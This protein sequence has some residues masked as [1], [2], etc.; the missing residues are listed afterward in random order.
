MSVYKKIFCSFF[1]I[2]TALLMFSCNIEKEITKNTG[3]A[4]HISTAV[5]SIVSVTFEHTA[6]LTTVPQT[7]EKNKVTTNP[8]TLPPPTTDAV[9]TNPVTLPPPTTDAGT[10]GEPEDSEFVRVRDYIEN[11]ITDLKYAT[12][13][14]FT[15]KRI[16]TFDEAYLRYGTVRKLMAVAEKLAEKGYAIKIWD[17]FRPAAAQFRLW[18]ICPD[19]TYVANPNKGFSSHSRGNTI[20]LTVYRISD[21]N[22]LIMPTGF[23]DFSKRA[24]RDYSDIEGEAAENA[25]MLENLMKQFGFKPYFGEWWHFSDVDSYPVEK[26]FLSDEITKG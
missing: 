20:D 21:Q 24:D 25:I 26:D 7:T 23:D 9:T 11:V 17:A 15:G 18:E 8:A 12:E 16:Y 3:S 19:S 6:E 22:E 4:E 10:S 5:N 1:V 2:L 13:D 14:N